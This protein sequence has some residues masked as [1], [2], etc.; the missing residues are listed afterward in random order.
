MI[1]EAPWNITVIIPEKRG[2]EERKK[3]S[4]LQIRKKE[5]KKE[6]KKVNYLQTKTNR[7]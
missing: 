1:C 2:G 5:R 7:K 4:D 6:R 3:E